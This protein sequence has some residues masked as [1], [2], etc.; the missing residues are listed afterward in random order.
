MGSS[1]LPQSGGIEYITNI[2]EFERGEQQMRFEA[3]TLPKIRLQFES[4][5]VLLRPPDLNPLLSH[6]LKA[7]EAVSCHAPNLEP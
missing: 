4:S 3:E 6:P 7:A 2:F 5:F 1:R